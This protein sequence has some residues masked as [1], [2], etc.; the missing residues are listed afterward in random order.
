MRG[1]HKPRNITPHSSGLGAGRGKQRQDEIMQLVPG[2]MKRSSDQLRGPPSAGPGSDQLEEAGGAARSLWSSC[3]AGT[4]ELQKKHGAA[5][6]V[7]VVGCPRELRTGR[8][9]E[10]EREL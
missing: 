4:A 8:R 9:R 6:D 1:A 3:L 2:K 5:V 7:W 10:E